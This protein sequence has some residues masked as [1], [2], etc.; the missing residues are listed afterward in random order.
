L[1]EKGIIGS[2]WVL[3]LVAFI[4]ENYHMTVEDEELIPENLDSI[5]NITEFLHR[6][7]KDMAEPKLIDSPP[8]SLSP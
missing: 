3:E 4:E 5:R 2:T 6:K 8:P 1:L 7:L